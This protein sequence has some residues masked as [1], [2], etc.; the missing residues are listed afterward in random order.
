MDAQELPVPQT[1]MSLQL[2]MGE[3][4]KDQECKEYYEIINLI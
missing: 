3:F 2:L 4:I 1:E